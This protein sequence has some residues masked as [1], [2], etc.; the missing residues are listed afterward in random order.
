VRRAA[1]LA[2]ACAL[3]LPATA[4]A[5]S[6]VRIGGDTVRYLSVDATSLNTLTVKLA[7]DR[8]DFT[9][10]TVD[11]GVDPGTC[12]P[13]EISDDANAWIVQAL[14]PRAGMASLHI[15][16]GERED[17]VTIDAALP[18]VLLGG[19]GAD[20]L[21]SG[22]GADQVTAGEG[23]DDASTGAGND[24]VDGGPGFDA[25]DGGDGDDVVRDADGLAD[26]LAC[27]P[28]ADRAE[29]D[30]ADVVAADCE[31]VTRTAVAPP[32]GAVVDDRR[33]PTVRA[34]GPVVQR[35]RRGR[36]H[37]LA[38]S[39][40]PGLL[41][42]SGSLDVAGISL[43][44]QSTRKRVAVAGGGAKLTVKLSRRHMRL[45]RR[46][47]ARGRRA[48]LRMFAVATD[49]AGNSR[50]AKAVRIRLRR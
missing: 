8:I 13:G 47:L 35:L 18:V 9:D 1:G 43:P 20:T 4:E 27:G 3:A 39:S 6:V 42:A 37:V 49:L 15:D 16:L 48:R 14:C 5:H 11:G 36:I 24:V 45:A 44:V 25:L 38:S 30:T 10:R 17:T 26:R 34:G 41:A 46:A 22:G 33:A 32:P 50:Q 21:R 31:T 40:E 7:G 28:G 12:D 23:N 2:L 29:A 19:P